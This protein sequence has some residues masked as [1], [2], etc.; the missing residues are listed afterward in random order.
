MIEIKDDNKST[1]AEEAKEVVMAE[2]NEI[3]MEEAT[4]EEIS[5]TRATFRKFMDVQHLMHAMRC[6]RMAKGGPMADAT[7][8]RGRIL[9]LL[10]LKDGV[11]TKEM[12]QILGIRVSSLNETLAKLEKDGLVERVP[13]EQDKRIML[14]QLTEAGKAIEEPRGHFPDRVFADFSDEEL[15]TL[16]GY[17]DRMAENVAA[18]AGEDAKEMLED[19]RRRRSEFFAK[20]HCCGHGKS[21]G[22]H[23]GHAH[24]GHGH[25]GCGCH[26]RKHEGHAHGG[27]GHGGCG[28]HEHDNRSHGGVCHGHGPHGRMHGHGCCEGHRHYGGH[29][30]GHGHCCHRHHHG[31]RW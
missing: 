8:G 21:G 29:G 24:G 27:H 1:K 5:P 3:T 25:G 17:L 19:M 7:R 12:A 14:V 22:H 16:G 23:E 30:H 10:K 31:P 6:R 18:G 2:E 11:A 13:S 20:K 26:E 15:E 9:A 4:L 28:C